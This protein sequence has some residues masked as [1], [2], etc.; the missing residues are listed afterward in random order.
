MLGH[1]ALVASG[2]GD[3]HLP[4]WEDGRIGRGLCLGIRMA[5]AGGMGGQ[6]DAGKRSN[7]AGN[8][9][10]S[11]RRRRQARVIPGASFC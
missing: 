9:V 5:E 3:D 10:S 2:D 7:S 1:V 4:L 11:E 8:D 6:G